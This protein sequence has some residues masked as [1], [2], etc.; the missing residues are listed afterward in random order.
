ME[1]AEEIYQRIIKEGQSAIDNFIFDRKSEELFLDFKRSADRG[2]GARLH[3]NDRNNLAKAISGFG[4][5]EGGVIVWGVDCSSDFDGSDVA[6]A[7][8][9]IIN[10]KRF[11]SWL[12]GS[13]SGL[14]VPPHQGVQNHALVISGGDNGFA[15]TL[16]PQSNHAPHQRVNKLQY[17]IRAGSD[18]VPTPHQVLAGMFGKRPQPN[19]ILWFIHQDPKIVDEK[20]ELELGFQIRNDGH[21]IAKDIFVNCMVFSSPILL[22]FK[23]EKSDWMGNFAYGRIMGLISKPEIRL[24]PD[25][26]IQPLCMDMILEPPFE[27]N[28]KVELSCGC[29]GA[30]IFRFNW[31]NSSENVEQLYN[32]IMAKHR[33]GTLLD[34]DWDGF[35]NKLLN[36]P[37]ETDPDF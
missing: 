8:H 5:S 20:I 10:V 19:L 37:L 2:N 35:T 25:A 34:E 29:S 15:I 16:I 9:P 1:R 7:K 27:K 36:L 30:P 32:E 23:P 22:G 24:A 21:G 31:E 17:Y 13:I 28:L 14:T 12:N 4:N 6:R 18:F 33:S 3:D 26:H 11:V